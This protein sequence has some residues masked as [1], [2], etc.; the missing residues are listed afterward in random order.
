MFIMLKSTNFHEIVPYKLQLSTKQSQKDYLIILLAIICWYD[1]ET[2]NK[3][4]GCAANAQPKSYVITS[5]SDPENQ[6]WFLL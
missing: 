2:N 6:R 4:I 5:Q 1:R 3:N